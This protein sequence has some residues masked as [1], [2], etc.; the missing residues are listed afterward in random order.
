MKKLNFSIEGLKKSS[1]WLLASSLVA[2]LTA[3]GGGSDNMGGG[4]GY[5]AVDAGDNAPYFSANGTAVETGANIEI[6]KKAANQVIPIVF[7]DD[8]ALQSYDITVDGLGA[9]GVVVG[10]AFSGLKSQVNLNIDQLNLDPEKIEGMHNL[11]VLAI[12]SAGQATVSYF[13]IS[14]IDE[15]KKVYYPFL[16]LVG[17]ATPGGWSDSQATPL[18]P[19]NPL[20]SFKFSWVGPLQS[21]EFKISTQ[22]NVSYANGF[23]WIHP[24]TQGQDLAS[25]AYSIVKSGVG[26]DNKW[27]IGEGQKGFYSITVLQKEDKIVILPVDK[28]YMVGDATPGGWTMGSSTILNRDPQD[29]SVFSTTV[30][31]KEGEFK[32]STQ[33]SNFDDGAWIFSKSSDIPTVETEFEFRNGAGDPDNKWKVTASTV[34]T[35]T[36]TVNLSSKTIIAIKQ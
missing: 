17:S 6:R 4:G 14:I 26:A 27:V 10:G 34:G 24:L 13:T 12:D 20:D 31:L 21:G 3:C 1:R 36:I 22:E 32:F 30:T 35:Y 7:F 2:V 25:T 9:E 33:R 23:D 29:S 16:R 28:L 15:T 11:K 8:K 5:K 19:A 18:I